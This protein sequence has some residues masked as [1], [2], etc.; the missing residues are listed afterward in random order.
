MGA[1][2]KAGEASTVNHDFSFNLSL[3]FPPT[4]L[5]IL[6]LRCRRTRI[7]AADGHYPVRQAEVSEDLLGVPNQFLVEAPALLWPT[8]DD[9]LH[10]VE[11]VRPED[12][13]RV[14]TMGS[15]LDSKAG[16][17]AAVPYG[18]RGT[19]ENL[20]HVPRDEWVFRRGDEVQVLTLD[21]VYD[22]PEGGEVHDPLVG[23]PAHHKG[24][25]DGLE[26]LPCQEVD[27]VAHDRMLQPHHLPFEEEGPRSCYLRGTLDIDH[28]QLREEVD[29][30]LRLEL[31][32]SR[33]SPTA[34]KKVVA[35]VLAVGI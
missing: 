28:P 15:R 6:R 10:L 25:F 27:G 18:E 20:V 1:L 24:R 11:L 14:L 8:E 30:V 7:A 23:P 35:F 13:L 33:L 12:A 19:L 4:S 21:L 5:P 26:S 34:K 17:E 29:V 31:E 16:A 3:S 32:F 2:P 22:G 9:L